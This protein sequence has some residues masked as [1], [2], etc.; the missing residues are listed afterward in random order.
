MAGLAIPSFPHST[1]DGGWLPATWDFRVAIHFAHRVMALVLT[2][3]IIALA[4]AV[5][6][7]AAASAGLKRLATALVILLGVQIALGAATVL[8]YRNPYYTT[9]HVIVG[10]ITLA[11]A[12]LLALWMYRPL[13][14]SFA[15]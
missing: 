7:Q 15:A 12:F 5:W 13:R 11:T 14:A 8:T 10:A 3:A 9:G 1:R 6:R 4:V 2:V